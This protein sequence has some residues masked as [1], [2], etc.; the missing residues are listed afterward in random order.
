MYRPGGLRSDSAPYLRK[1][2]AGPAGL[3]E[4]HRKRLILCCAADG[5]RQRATRPSLR[6]WVQGVLGRLGDGDLGDVLR[7]ARMRQLGRAGVRC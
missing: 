3:G 5:C 1:P 6:F 7:T 4:E 2:H